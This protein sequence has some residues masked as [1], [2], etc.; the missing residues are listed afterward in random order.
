MIQI[1]KS[2]GNSLTNDRK[3]GSFFRVNW[4]CDKCKKYSVVCLENGAVE[5]ETLRS[6]NFYIV[7]MPAYKSASIV[8]TKDTEKKIIKSFDMDEFT[9]EQAAHWATKLKTYVLFQ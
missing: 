6:G 1:C 7:F 2:C 4:S 5:S 8:S 9:A 3:P